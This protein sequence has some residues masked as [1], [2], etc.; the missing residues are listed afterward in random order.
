MPSRM[1]GH[2]IS[3]SAT[4]CQRKICN[5]STDQKYSADPHPHMD[6]PALRA[7]LLANDVKCVDSFFTS[8]PVILLMSKSNFLYIYIRM[9]C[10]HFLLQMKIDT[11]LF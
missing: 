7:S 8:D 4:F 1:V 9:I 3:K 10:V 6:S 11:L 5:P 2:Y